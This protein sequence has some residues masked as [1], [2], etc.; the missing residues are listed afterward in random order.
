VDLASADVFVF[1]SRTD[2]IGIVLHED[3]ATAV[4]GALRLDHSA[5]RRAAL[6]HTWERAKEQFCAHLAAA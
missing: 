6:Q 4:R 2:T 1:P 5:C 3:L